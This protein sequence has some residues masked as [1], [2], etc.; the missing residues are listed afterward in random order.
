MSGGSIT[1]MKIHICS[2]VAHIQEGETENYP[3]PLLGSNYSSI[4]ET[5]MVPLMQ[6]RRTIKV[7]WNLQIKTRVATSTIVVLVVIKTRETGSS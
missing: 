4:N 3:P 2:D 6:Y 5:G 7:L 1:A